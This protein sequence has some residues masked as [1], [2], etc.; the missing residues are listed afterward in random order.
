L[1]EIMNLGIA[2][3]T[4]SMLLGA[5]DSSPSPSTQA[6]ADSKESARRVL[7]L[8][9]KYD[10][11]AEPECK[12]KLALEA[13]PLLTYSN[14]VRGDVYGNVFVWT[15]QGRPEVIGAIF[16]F[17]SESKLDSELHMLSHRGAVGCREGEKFWSPDQP[18]AKFAA[19]PA[20]PVPAESAAAR[21]RQMRDLAKKFTVERDHPEQGKGEVRLLSQ[22]IYRYSSKEAGILDGAIFAF[23]EGTDPEAY[24]L[25]EAT[26]A[27]KP[28][29]QFAF[30]RM[31]IVEFRALYG[32]KEVWKV[33]AVNWDVVFDKQEPYA[34]IRE[35]PRRGLKRSP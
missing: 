29:W 4:V 16:D 34:I 1:E 3:I 27:G 19:L 21:L 28:Q 23:V 24:L 17:R 14:P 20:A 26:A 8:A 31:N 5:D 10:F 32:G 11:Y 15:L 12:T 25:L 7:E 35:S 6:N 2:V 30:A 18:G 22:P 33:P 9:Q 13:K